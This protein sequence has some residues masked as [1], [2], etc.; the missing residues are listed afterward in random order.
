MKSLLR[1]AILCSFILCFFGVVQAQYPDLS[2]VVYTNT[3][4]NGSFEGEQ[5]VPWPANKPSLPPPWIWCNDAGNSPDQQ[6]GNWL[7]TAPPYVGKNYA[8]MISKFLSNGDIYHE[9]FAAPLIFQEGREH[10]LT[11][12][13]ANNLIQNNRDS[14]AGGRLQILLRKYRYCL[15]EVDPLKDTIWVSE[16]IKGEE[17]QTQIINFTPSVAEGFLVFEARP[18]VDSAD[19][20]N[21]SNILI[22][23]VSGP[24]PGK[25]EKPDLGRDQEFCIGDTVWLESEIQ[26]PAT[27]YIWQDGS[28]DSR[29]RVTE[30][31]RYIVTYIGGGARLSDTIDVT[32]IEPIQL[33]FPPD[34]LLC[35]ENEFLLGPSRTD[36]EYLWSDGVTESPRLVNREGAYQLRASKGNCIVTDSAL[37]YF[38]TCAD[39]LE[40][41]NVFTPNGDGIHDVFQPMSFENIFSYQLQVFDRWGRVIAKIGST[42]GSWDGTNLNGRPAPEGVYFYV[43]RYQ[44]LGNEEVKVVKGSVTLVR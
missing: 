36:Y 7:V 4:Q 10:F 18:A 19:Y 35:R 15:D 40:M 37:F 29:L 41:P 14:S 30:S 33:S 8:G 31:G 1:G 12:H 28:R 16:V 17:W 24:F 23:G 9:N 2:E 25:F 11:L 43:V 5:Y 44:G 34:T 6:P 32:F 22:D 42:Y 13:L 26:S 20:I 27:T 21:L 38:R 3:I 39:Q